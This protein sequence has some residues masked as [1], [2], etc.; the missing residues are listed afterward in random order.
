MK[1]AE[2]RKT[3]GANVDSQKGNNPHKFKEKRSQ[4]KV[5]SVKRGSEITKTT[6]W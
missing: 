1:K 6:K 3:V 4:S 5:I 2:Y